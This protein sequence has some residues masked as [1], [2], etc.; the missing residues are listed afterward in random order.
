MY[1]TIA[2]VII[3]LIFLVLSAD[4]FGA[5]FDCSRASTDVEILICDSPELNAMDDVLNV[6]Y[7]MA[8][9]HPQ[10]NELLGIL[11]EWL[12][13]RNACTNANCLLG[14]YDQF[15]PFF[16]AR[17]T[18]MSE[19][20]DNLPTRPPVEA[21]SKSLEILKNPAKA[22][23][24]NVGQTL[25]PKM[26][27]SVDVVLVS[28]FNYLKTLNIWVPV[29]IALLIFVLAQVLSSKT[30]CIII[31]EWWD[32]MVLVV[33]GFIVLSVFYNYAGA[34]S[35]SEDYGVITSILF[36][37]FIMLSVTLTLISNKL[38]LL[39]SLASVAM[40]AVAILVIPVIIVLFIFALGAGKK[41]GRYSDGTRGNAQ[42]LWLSVVGFLGYIIIGNLIKS[43]SRVN[44]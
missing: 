8:K 25:A 9:T 27:M 31:W 24:F 5:G 43:R 13:K 3:T 23:G 16:E 17:V 10:K 14:A 15:L 33:P 7:Q 21:E 41:D 40:K 38:N 20:I 29:V 22:N 42:T 32:L 44:P 30:E 2:K 19:Q 37:S 6:L 18:H 11:R 28:I 34:K 4:S 26:N 35:Q 39:Y 36:Y 12:A 1:P